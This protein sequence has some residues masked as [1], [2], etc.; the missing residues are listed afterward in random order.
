MKKVTFAGFEFRDDRDPAMFVIAHW[1]KTEGITERAAIRQALCLQ[2]SV[3]AAMGSGLPQDRVLA[4]VTAARLAIG[5]YLATLDRIELLLTGAVS[6]PT[7]AIAQATAPMP[8]RQ[9][10]VEENHFASVEDAF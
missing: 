6:Q 3:E 2:Y 5:R 7:Q 8:A 10:E 1:L 9:V 4:E